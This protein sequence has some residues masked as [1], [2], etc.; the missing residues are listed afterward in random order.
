[1]SSRRSRKRK[2]KSAAQLSKARWLPNDTTRAVTIP[3]ARK[4]E[5]KKQ[6]RGRSA[7]LRGEDLTG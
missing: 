6:A 5:N 1:V 3:D 7:R 2:K 4:V